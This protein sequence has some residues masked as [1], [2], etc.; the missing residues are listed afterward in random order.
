M[1]DGFRHPLPTA[2]LPLPRELRGC[3]GAFLGQGQRGDL[4][5]SLLFIRHGAR[6]HMKRCTLCPR[7]RQ[8]HTYCRLCT[9][10]DQE[11]WLEM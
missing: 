3:V 5:L 7:C 10:C 11:L 4:S 6:D 1:T 8:T 9:A 2:V